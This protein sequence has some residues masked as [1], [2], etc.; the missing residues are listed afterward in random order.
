M[1]R[2][3][4]ALALALISAAVICPAAASAQTIQIGTSKSKL[5]VPPCTGACTIVLT[6]DTA[7]QSKSYS[8][9]NPMTI[10]SAG[11]ITSFGVGV[12]GLSSK[13]S[14]RRQQIAVGDSTYGGP[15]SVRLTVLAPVGNPAAHNWR[16]VEQSPAMAIVTHLGTIARFTLATPLPV[17]HGE[18]LALT[19][20]TWAPVLMAYP[21]TQVSQFGYQQDRFSGCTGISTSPLNV[22]SLI[23]EFANYGCSYVGTRV[24]YAAAEEESS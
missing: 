15:P 20:P 21:S 8:V 4:K 11:R 12:S 14:T 16:V 13:A 23:G 22:Q 18:A 2:S 3:L 5:A 10:V 1:Q 24:E 6:E 17:T 19:V 9:L 7:L